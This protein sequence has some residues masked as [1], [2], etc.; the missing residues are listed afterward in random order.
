MMHSYHYTIPSEFILY[1]LRVYLQFIF[2]HNFSKVLR[3][4]HKSIS[5]LFYLLIYF[6]QILKFRYYLN[7][8]ISKHFNNTSFI[9]YHWN[10]IWNNKS[11]NKIIFF[12]LNFNMISFIDALAS[13]N[14]DKTTSKRMSVYLLCKYCYKFYIIM[15]QKIIS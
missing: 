4:F 1:Q 8:L 13:I 14:A 6:L 15:N 7:L 2:K 10:K 11:W 3:L 12:N 9:S 5:S